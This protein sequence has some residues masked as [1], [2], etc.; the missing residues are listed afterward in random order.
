[1]ATVS[2]IH[3]LIN[4]KTG[5]N[6]G[7]PST[8]TFMKDWRLAGAAASSVQTNRW[9]S[10]WL[11][12][13]NPGPGPIP[14]TAAACDHTTAGGLGIPPAGGG[15]QKFLDSVSALIGATNASLVIYD[16]LLHCGGLSA[17]NLAA[18]TVGGTITRNTTGVGNQIWVEVY[19]G[20]GAN[21]ARGVVSYTNQDGVSGRTTSQLTL[22]N[23]S[24][25]TNMN[26]V[27]RV[28]QLTL[29][30]GDTGVQSVENVDLSVA[31]N[32]AGNFGITIVR[33]IVQVLLDSFSV[34][35]MV[36]YSDWPM[37]DIGSA[38]LSMMIG[39][40]STTSPPYLGFV[41]STLER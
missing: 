4:R 28:Q 16:R 29:Q 20:I 15:R 13:G 2:D 21:P 34:A 24:D 6:S 31:S 19:G 5:G 14:S 9:N 11:L 23:P 32:S 41:A 37:F 38:C 12:D 10:T 39:H 35:H 7:S 17:T 1:M 26:M 30:A 22:G 3:E 40:P 8:F 18:Q 33:P 36:Q 27:Q 25:M